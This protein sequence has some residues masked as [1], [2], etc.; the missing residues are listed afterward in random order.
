[1]TPIKIIALIFIIFIVI[2]L[3]VICIKPASWRPVV[4]TIY[5]NSV[6]TSIAAFILAIVILRYLLE[7]LTIVQIF[8]SMTFMMALMMV[9]FALLGN[10]VMALADKFLNDRSMLRKVWL[11][12]ALWI[13]LIGW[14][15]CEIFV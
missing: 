8:A 15:L 6:V 11:S 7:E 10:E 12:L 2:K 3:V 1:M 14:V 5:G 13:I 9:Q 4:K